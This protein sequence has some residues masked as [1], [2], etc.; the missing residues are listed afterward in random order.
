MQADVPNAGQGLI[1]LLAQQQGAQL[2]SQAMQQTL[3]LLR[4]G[5]TGAVQR[6]LA[7]SVSMQEKV[8]QLTHV[9]IAMLMSI[10]QIGGLT[11]LHRLYPDHDPSCRLAGIARAFLRLLMLLVTTFTS[12]VWW[13]GPLACASPALCWMCQRCP[14]HWQHSQSATRQLCAGQGLEKVRAAVALS[15]RG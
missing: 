2:D 13:R 6:L 1:G 11:D 10:A 3:G 9:R 5:D 14:T 4:N 8:R 7:S 15:F 12:A